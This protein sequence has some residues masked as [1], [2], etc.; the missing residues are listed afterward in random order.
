M[1]D[2]KSVLSNDGLQQAIDRTTDPEA[3]KELATALAWSERVNWAIG[4]TVKGMPPLPYVRESL[5]KMQVRADVIVVSSTP[6]EA[7][8]REWGEH[9]IAKYA[10][11]LAGQE[12]GKKA[13]HLK[14][15]TEG[16][17]VKDHVL[18]IGD[19]PGDMEAAKANDVLFYPILPGN[20]VESWKR[21]H[22]EVFDEFLNGRYAGDYEAGRIAEFDACLPEL[23]PWVK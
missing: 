12:Q 6:V 22:D 17:Y 13:E 1:N 8:R 10:E 7:L 4:E 14:I 19:A 23:P 15:A 5:E 3:K 20:E 21:F 18:M 9:D 16:R 11:V 2:P